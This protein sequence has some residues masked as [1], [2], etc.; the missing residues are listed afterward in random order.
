MQKGQSITELQNKAFLEIISNEEIIRS[1]VVSNTDFLYATP[2]PQEKILIDDPT[3]LIRKQLFPYRRIPTTQD[4]A[5]IYLTSAW[6]DFKKVNT[7]YKSG[8][9]YF[10]IIVP[11]SMEKSDY[12]I[13]YNFIADKLDEIF[14][15]SGIG[16][17][18]YY[19]R[20][21]ID[22]SDGYLGHFIAFRI[23]DFHGW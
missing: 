18:E 8:L 5:K 23:L 1:M 15:S 22:I 17:F 3:L 20:G 2:T 10:Y 4:T 19:N 11:I 7:Q 14:Y 21:D 16:K 6:T 12:G 9:V 13:R